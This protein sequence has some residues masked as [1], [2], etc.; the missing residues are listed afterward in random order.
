MDSLSSAIPD[1]LPCLSDADSE[2]LI[3]PISFREVYHTLLSMP[4]RKSQGPD[5]MNVEF[6]VYYWNAIGEKLFQA[7]AYFFETS[8]IPPEW[9]KTFVVL[10][11]KKNNPCLVIDF[12]PISLCNVYYK[13]L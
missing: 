11:P 4:R 2:C 8:S 5:G 10:I 13:L 6:Y 7:I 9:G 3:R 12:R 1:D